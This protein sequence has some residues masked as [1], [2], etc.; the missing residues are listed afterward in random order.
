MP[1]KRKDSPVWWINYI[2]SS[3]KRIRQSTGTTDK[4]EAKA[5]EAKA[6]LE[7][8][9][10]KQWDEK[11][12]PTFDEVMVVYLTASEG[13]QSYPR[14]KQ[15]T[16]RLRLAFGG[17]AIAAITPA[18]I[19]DYIAG[20][21]KTVSPS[22]V[23]RELEVFSAAVNYCRAYLGW[24]LRNPV[25]RRSLKE[26]EGRVRWITRQE[27]VA[28]MQATASSAAPYLADLVTTALYTGMRRG[29]LLGLEWV[30]VDLTND[31]IY[32]EAEHT[33]AKKR[34]AIPLNATARAAILSRM[35]WRAK[36]CPGSRWVFSNIDGQRIDS[37]KRSWATACKRAGI[38][39]YR[40]HDL[41]HT[42]AAWLVSEGV[43]LSE[44]R[45]LLGHSSV[46]VTERYA[47]L[48]PHRVREAVKILDQSR[49]G[50]VNNKGSDQK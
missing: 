45:D 16:A 33:K 28:L 19:T 12:E 22:S 29:E 24:R 17:V 46:K 2:D 8:Y 42:C 21:R 27:A 38:E 44:V 40:F 31:L 18:M 30:R 32:L 10:I 47:H 26:P 3:G 50:H 37:V 41:R 13:K 35:R 25:E 43:P 11:P 7:A 14:L 1:Y 48:S 49:F 23:N 9:R 4:T 5:L 39:D 6:K 34:R 15:H 20:R 36:H